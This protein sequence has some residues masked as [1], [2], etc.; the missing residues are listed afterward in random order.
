MSS[1]IDKS[2]LAW[3]P[4][5]PV[6][7]EEKSAFLEKLPTLKNGKESLSMF[8]FDA[9]Y[10]HGYDYTDSDILNAIKISLLKSLLFRC[11]F[12]LDAL[13][14]KSY[15]KACEVFENGEY[16]SDILS[17]LIKCFNHAWGHLK[18][19]NGKPVQMDCAH[20]YPLLK[21]DISYYYSVIKNNQIDSKYAPLKSVINQ[22]V[23]SIND[24]CYLNLKEKSKLNIEL[25]SYII[26]TY[27]Y[28]FNTASNST[29]YIYSEY[30]GNSVNDILQL[31][32]L[33]NKDFWKSKDF[34]VVAFLNNV[35][36]NN[37]EIQAQKI[38]DYIFN[39]LK[40]DESVSRLIKNNLSIGFSK[41][42]IFKKK[43]KDFAIFNGTSY[44]I[45]YPFF[46][47]ESES[48]KISEGKRI[49]ESFLY[50]CIYPNNKDLIT[51]KL[52]KSEKTDT[53]PTVFDILDFCSLGYIIR[54]EE[55]QALSILLPDF[56][57][58][59]A[60][61]KRAYLKAYYL[62]SK[63]AQFSL[64]K[65]LYTCFYPLFHYLNRE[66]EIESAVQL[67]IKSR[68]NGFNMLKRILSEKDTE[69]S[70]SE[71]YV[72][73]IIDGKSA[74]KIEADLFPMLELFGSA[75]Y[76]FAV[77][78][79][80]FYNPYYDDYTENAKTVQFRFNSYTDKE[81]KIKI[82]K[83]ISLEKAYISAS[84]VNNKYIYDYFST[85]LD[86]KSINNLG[87]N[88]IY[89]KQTLDMLLGAIALD[90]GYN[91]SIKLAKRLIIDTFPTEFKT[92]A[93]YTQSDIENGSAD[94]FYLSRIL[95]ELN[96]KPESI[97]YE[98]NSLM[99]DNLYRL[100]GCIILKTDTQSKRD[101]ISSSM[102]KLSVLL[103]DTPYLNTVSPIYHFYLNNG[104]DSTVDKYK[105]DILL[106]YKTII[107]S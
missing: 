67:D 59:D 79:M 87:D 8:V 41:I 36:K 61:W 13:G 38:I 5:F 77:A 31:A 16:C 100:L 2:G 7:N 75:I 53:F 52:I 55:K 102:N 44:E 28:D 68:Q 85:T 10:K 15:K 69:I 92:E 24:A 83:I 23:P 46:E 21:D 6:T 9:L 49:F 33:N 78:E 81:A 1:Q 39:E 72:A 65:K 17:E 3:S 90:L 98:Y 25:N 70:Y 82:A 34:S 42:D 89:L 73:S 37:D 88:E 32:L 101:L 30:F 11:D 26:D 66:L 48:A 18:L 43:F 62:K 97:D 86:F 96:S 51:E 29:D 50:D 4:F 63:A 60:I 19:P 35:A 27:S 22:I 107:Q 74:T 12:A 91:A 94:I 14:E 57:T 106:K 99:R 40:N 84:N 76:D 105:N 47:I 58:Y 20:I 64:N 56:F 71:Y 104:L 93:H 103:G 54:N 80:I 45:C 95:P